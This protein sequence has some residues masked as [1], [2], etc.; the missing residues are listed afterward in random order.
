MFFKVSS[1]ETFSR[2]FLA[3]SLEK[4]SASIGGV[5]AFF[6]NHVNVLRGDG[7]GLASACEIRWVAGV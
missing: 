3:A 1:F 5:D 2:M 4:V 6:S 7:R